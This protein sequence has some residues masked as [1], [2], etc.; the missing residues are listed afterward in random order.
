[1]NQSRLVLVLFVF[2]ISDFIFEYSGVKAACSLGI[3][4]AITGANVAV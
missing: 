3:K 2:G 1:M 4:D